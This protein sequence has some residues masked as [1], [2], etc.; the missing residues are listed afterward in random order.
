MINLQEETIIKMHKLMTLFY[1]QNSYNR[2]PVFVFLSVNY[3]GIGVFQSQIPFEE[4]CAYFLWPTSGYG[5]AQVELTE[6][7][8]QL[9]SSTNKNN[10]HNCFNIRN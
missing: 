6:V 4:Q 9:T 2:E 7:I 10:K 8:H 1:F 3:L 5:A